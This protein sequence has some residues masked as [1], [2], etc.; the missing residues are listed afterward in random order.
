MRDLL[1]DIEELFESIED[2]SES[3]EM[4]IGCLNEGIDR[5]SEY[6]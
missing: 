2:G 6:A 5:M 3:I 1:G 4:A